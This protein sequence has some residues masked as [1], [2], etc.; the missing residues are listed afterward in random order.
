MD[1]LDLTSEDLQSA[2]PFQLKIKDRMIILINLIEFK[3]KDIIIRKNT[4][5][6]MV[7]RVQ[8]RPEQLA[9]TKRVNKILIIYSDKTYF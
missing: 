8:E 9:Q 3:I 1:L 6:Y 2:F 5:I 7:Q 4:N